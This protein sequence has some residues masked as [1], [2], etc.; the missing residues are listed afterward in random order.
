MNAS[1]GNLMPGPDRSPDALTELRGLARTV[2]DLLL[3]GNGNELLPIR[4]C[5]GWPAL[6]WTC[7]C[8]GT[9][10]N[11]CPYGTAGAGPHCAGPASARERKRTPAHTELRGLARTVLDLLLPGNGNELLPIR[12]CGGWPALC[13][14]C[15]C[16][17]TETNSCPYGTAGAGPHCAGP[18]SA[19][20]RK[21]APAHTELRGLART[22]LDL[23]L[24]GNGNELLPIGTTG[25]PHYPYLK[26]RIFGPGVILA[27]VA[28]QHIVDDYWL[29]QTQHGG[30]N[31]QGRIEVVTG[32]P[33]A[34]AILRIRG[35]GDNLLDDGG[36]VAQ[37]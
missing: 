36:E 6:C 31:E 23:L 37:F 10:T 1:E 16:P 25:W 32:P 29:L 30:V 3:P 24:P 2:L 5:G 26:T 19:R 33:M 8:P 35:S 14:T 21:R 20:E 27:R 22:V 34:Q 15:F 13:W 7:F 28:V 17:G 9:E 11:S 4:N 12:N 18:A